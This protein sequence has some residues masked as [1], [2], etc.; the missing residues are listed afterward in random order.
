M[1]IVEIIKESFIFP[2]KNLDKLAI[3]AV[4]SL[5]L[6]LLIVGGSFIA[7]IATKTSMSY[8]ILTIICFIL[9]IVVALIISGYQLSILKS[10]IDHD[11]NA[12]GFEWKK[13][14]IEG[15][16]LLVVNIV[17]FIIPAII[18]SIVALITNIPGQIMDITQKAA[19]SPA[20]AT[21]VANSTGQLTTVS[22]SAMASLFGSIA[23]TGV[24]ALILIIIF[25][26]IATMGESRLANTGSLSEALNIVESAKD[27]TRIGIG[28]VIAVILLMII[29]VAV[30]QAILG[31]IYGQV[32]QL[33]IISI[34]VTPYLAFFTHRVTGLLYS[35][36][37]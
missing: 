19:L 5:V 33:A 16:K 18:I 24:I 26:F 3:Y 8:L 1:E 11:E 32:P 9:A 25:A 36:I 30:I 35:D 20:N 22:Q 37:A 28:K 6:G 12:P 10:G 21:A 4:V 17:Y 13:N 29:V 31:Y 7:V 34:I 2:S 15:I 23:I 14:L 27:I